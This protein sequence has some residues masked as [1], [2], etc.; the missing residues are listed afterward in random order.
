MRVSTAGGA[1]AGGGGGDSG[2]GGV[3]EGRVAM[4]LDLV[5]EVKGVVVKDGIHKRNVQRFVKGGNSVCLK[6]RK[7]I[8]AGTQMAKG[9]RDRDQEPYHRPCR[10]V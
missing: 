7:A 9:R 8:V 10:A 5:V 3:V 2:V 6:T 1:V 4:M